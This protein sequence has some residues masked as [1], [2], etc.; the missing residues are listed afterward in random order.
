MDSKRPDLR[1]VLRQGGQS[2]A[3]PRLFQRP[4][5]TRTSRH[6]R[7]TGFWGRLAVVQV[8]CGHIAVDYNGLI[9]SRISTSRA[10]ET[11]EQLDEGVPD[12]ALWCPPPWSHLTTKLEDALISGPRL[13]ALNIR[14]AETSG[15]TAPSRIFPA[16]FQAQS[17]LGHW[18]DD[19]DLSV[20]VCKHYRVMPTLGRE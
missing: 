6:A 17:V 14:L 20:N 11:S 5:K 13:A 16:V 4:S 10:S 19:C 18:P 9:R 8:P 1:L 2:D 12:G 15:Q 3:P 7:L